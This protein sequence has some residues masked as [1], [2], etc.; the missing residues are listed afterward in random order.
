MQNQIEQTEKEY[1]NSGRPLLASLAGARQQKHFLTGGERGI[2]TP[3]TPL[4]AYTR[5]PVVLL[6]PLGHLSGYCNMFNH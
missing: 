2:R 1:K 5:F 4:R 6:K 3:G